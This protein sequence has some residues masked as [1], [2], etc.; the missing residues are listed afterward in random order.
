MEEKIREILDRILPAKG[1]E[2]VDLE[3]HPN[4]RSPLVR[5]FIDRLGGVTV[6][7]C[8][9]V[10]REISI[11]FQVEESI[12]DT[13]LLEVSSPGIERPFKTQ[14]DYERNLNR[15]IEVR[16]KA[17]NRVLTTEGVLTSVSAE[18]ISVETK[19]GALEL[20]LN[21]IL[22]ARQQLSF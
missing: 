5:I 2:L 7:D 8:S 1:M 13:A 3:I 21:L 19:S 11:H 14:R 10:A 20:P 4:G 12:P 22:M 9:E 18:K 6:R 15:K 17:D 16:Y